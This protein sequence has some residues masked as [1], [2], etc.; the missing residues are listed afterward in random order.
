MK[1]TSCRWNLRDNVKEKFKYEK[2]F[3]NLDLRKN[4]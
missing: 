3:Y 2:E 4:I 1:F